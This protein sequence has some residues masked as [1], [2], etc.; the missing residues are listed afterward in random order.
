MRKSSGLSAGVGGLPALEVT[1]EPSLAEMTE[2]AI[3]SLSQNGNGLHLN[4]KAGRV[5]HA[6]H[7]G[8]LYRTLTDGKAFA[9]AIAK[10]M[11]LTRA[12]DTLIIVTANRRC[13]RTQAWGVTAPYPRML[14]PRGRSGRCR[15]R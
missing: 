8:N 1:G 3:M 4:I 11:E 2:A 14:M 5:D 10:A 6:D 7:D 9:D 15:G 12:E 13:C